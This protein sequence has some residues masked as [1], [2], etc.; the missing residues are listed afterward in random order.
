MLK[1]SLFVV[2]LGLA[3]S[4]APAWAS[5]DHGAAD[6]KEKKASIRLKKSKHAEL[7]L[8]SQ[9]L[10]EG[11]LELA[12]DLFSAISPGKKGRTDDKPIRSHGSVAGLP[13]GLEKRDYGSRGH[14]HWSGPATNGVVPAIP[15][16]S[17]LLFFAVGLV[18][19][20]RAL[21][22]TWH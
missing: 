16:P 19:A 5:P 17:A 7:S 11:S 4:N 9:S 20:R 1:K 8:P 18:V 13:P 6:G 22:A 21:G 3:L 2:A 12:G 15:E 10:M 14:G